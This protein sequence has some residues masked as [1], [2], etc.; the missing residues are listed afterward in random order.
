MRIWACGSIVDQVTGSRITG[1][2]FCH[3][4]PMSRLLKVRFAR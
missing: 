1:D 2:H 3:E 4:D